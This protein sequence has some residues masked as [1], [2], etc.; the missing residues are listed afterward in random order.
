VGS[1]FQIANVLS[2]AGGASS[3]GERY[4]IHDVLV[5]DVHWKDYKSF[6]NFAL[7]MSATPP[8][9]DV[10]IEHVTAFVPHFLISIQNTGQKFSGFTV[11]NNLFYSGDLQFTSAGG[12]PQNCAFRPDRQG[13]AGVIKNCFE[14]SNF[15]HNVVVEGDRWPSGNITPK[16]AA[17]AGLPEK[18][19]MGIARYRLCRKKDEFCKNV[20]PAIAAGTDG[21]D[22][23]A[24]A[25]AIERALEGVQ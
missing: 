12:G 19:T 21:K 25:D 22:I 1:V 24:D 2:D 6:G 4:S 7:V 8:L 3:G 14:N 18:G 5:D 17:A 11:A 23:G 9:R 13:P 10:R 16:N 20:S 15:T